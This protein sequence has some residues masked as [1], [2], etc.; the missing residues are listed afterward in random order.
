MLEIENLLEE[1]EETDSKK[2]LI[3]YITSSLYKLA[4]D[5][6]A[7]PKKFLLLI[8]AISMLNVKDESAITAAKKLAQMNVGKKR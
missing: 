1:V 3:N 4:N 7:D 2:N 8:A 5:K 6:E